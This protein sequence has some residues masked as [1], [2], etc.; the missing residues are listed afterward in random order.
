MNGHKEVVRA[1]FGMVRRWAHLIKPTGKNDAQAVLDALSADEFPD[2]EMTQVRG[3]HGEVV[4]SV[5]TYPFRPQPVT[6]WLVPYVTGPALWSSM[7]APPP[8]SDG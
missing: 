3:P 5:E 8:P 1:Y 6:A 2:D 7:E 4:L